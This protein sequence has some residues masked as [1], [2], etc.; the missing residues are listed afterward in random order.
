MNVV[1]SIQAPAGRK[2]LAILAFFALLPF[3]VGHFLA[4]EIIIWSIFVIGYNVLLGYGGE[5]S[6]GHAALIG[7]G[8][9]VT[10]MIVVYVVESIVLAVILAIVI[11]TLITVPFAYI[12][13]RRRGIY[14]AMITLALA[15]IFYFVSIQG[16]DY[17][18]GDDGLALPAL[19]EAPG[20]LDLTRGGLEFYVF[21]LIVLA[22]VWLGVYR[23]VNSPYGLALKAIR[24]NEKRADHLGYD[25]NKYLLGAF[26][27]SGFIS[28]IAGAMYA[29]MYNFVH[30]TLL[31]WTTSGDVVLMALLGGIGTLGGPIAGA[32][33]YIIARETIVGLT[34]HWEIFFGLLVIFTVLFAPEG[35]WGLYEKHVKGESPR[36]VLK[37]LLGKI[38]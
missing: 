11:T 28:G 22:L 1:E 4:N 29:L 12:S 14:L 33:V 34:D 32:A 21:G 37:E 20:P 31:F 15:M 25:A 3:V 27:V 5:L 8:A 18:G 30:P 19:V 13:L 23:L 16:R 38:R 7:T 9:F 2:M 36:E 26:V 10:V 17:T 24:E 6:F 35:V